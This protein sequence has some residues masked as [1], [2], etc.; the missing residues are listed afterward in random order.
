[1]TETDPYALWDAAYVLGSLSST[2]RRDYEAHLGECASCRSAVGEL[3]GMPALLAMLPPDEVAAID[4]RGLAPPPMR[5]GLLEDVLARVQ[6]QR[7]RARWIN[8]TVAAVAAAVLAVAAVLA[9]N[10]AQFG[11]TPDRLP[12]ASAAALP[13]TPVV[14]S[15][16]EASVLLT[17]HGWGTRVE[18]TCTYRDEPGAGGDDGDRLAM[19]AVGRDGSRT[20]LATWMAREGATASPSGSTSMPVADIAAV[21]VVSADTGDVLLQRSL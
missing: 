15:S 13:M 17:S 6:R 9:T 11:L 8:W 1:V 19:Y 21:Q 10:P 20:Q 3:S 7:R 12:S 4:D 16:F 14:P 18:M 5:Q 2:D